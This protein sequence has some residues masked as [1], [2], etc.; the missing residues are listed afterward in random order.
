MS[1]NQGTPWLTCFHSNDLAKSRFRIRMHIRDQ[2]GGF[3]AST[4]IA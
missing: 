4:E 1:R 2:A 3:C